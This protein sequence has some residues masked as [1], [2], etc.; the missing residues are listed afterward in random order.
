WRRCRPKRAPSPATS[1]RS[2]R[3]SGNS[4]TNPIWR[5]WRARPAASS[6]SSTTAWMPSWAGGRT[7]SPSSPTTSPPRMKGPSMKIAMV[8]EHASPL[9]LLGGVDAGGQNVHVAEL[10]AAL[11]R[12]GH[13]VVVY[14]R[15][16]D[17]RAPE[18]VT[19]DQ[20]YRVVHV[21]PGPARVLPKDE[22]LP[23]MDAFGDFLRARWRAERPD[24]VH[25]HFW[26]SGLA[27]L[28]AARPA[29]IPVV[30]TFHALGVVKHRYQ[31]A[32]DTSP[33][34]RIELEQRIAQQADRIIATCTD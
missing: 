11:S 32:D 21:P 28:A 24:V 29:D 19:T 31:G 16:D 8:S 14:T 26:M 34:E 25:A 33:P 2:P 17:P 13:D 15:R 6:P 4:C 23:H 27:A 9:A 30:Q 12:Q 10:A 20:G 18:R 22:L 5:S 7:C 1:P 3:S